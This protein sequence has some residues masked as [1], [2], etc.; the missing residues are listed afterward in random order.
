MVV[1][2]LPRDWIAAPFL[3]L[4]FQNMICEDRTDVRGASLTAWKTALTTIPATSGHL[5][6]VVTQQMIIDW[7]AIMMTPL[8]IP[9]DISTF[10]IPSMH[11]EG[12]MP[13]ERHNVDKN[14][15]S[16][17]LSLISV[18]IVIKARLATAT[19]LG[20]L[21]VCWM[22]DVSLLYP[23]RRAEFLFSTAKRHRI[24]LQTYSPS[25]SRLLEHAPEISHL[26][27]RR[28]MGKAIRSLGFGILCLTC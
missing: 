19:A 20:Y 10:Y 15:I 14:M 13:L 28:R 9:I 18:N 22:S 24:V 8:G 25:L 21:M 27:C 12:N 26:R 4:L 2:S 5:E 6:N 17:D 16:Q 1:Q 7:Y 23:Y 11:L 3:S